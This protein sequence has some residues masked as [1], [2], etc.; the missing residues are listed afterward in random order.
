MKG[1]ALKAELQTVH[2]PGSE[3][4]IRSFLPVLQPCLLVLCGTKDLFE[5]RRLTYLH[6]FRTIFKMIPSRTGAVFLLWLVVLGVS[7]VLPCQASDY[8][9]TIAATTSY[10]T[11][12]M[13]LDHIPG[14]AIAL[15]ES[16]QVVWA[17]GF[18]YADLERW[19]PVTPQTVYRVGS[20]S[21]TF[22]AVALLQLEEQGLL[23]MDTPLTNVLPCPP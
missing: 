20:V 18:G 4:R 10:I 2:A 22:P 6:L 11:N 12:R 3:S 15:V 5:E 19:V 17:A 8:T 23:S 21:K 9:D 1:L 16:Q 14:L 7:G 13:A